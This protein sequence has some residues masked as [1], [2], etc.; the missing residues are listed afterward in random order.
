M[1]FFLVYPGPV[2]FT[3]CVESATKSVLYVVTGPKHNKSEFFCIKLGIILFSRLELSI[4][5]AAYSVGYIIYYQYYFSMDDKIG[6]TYT[7]D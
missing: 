7:I 1:F 4:V 3:R 6:R 2:L 5:N